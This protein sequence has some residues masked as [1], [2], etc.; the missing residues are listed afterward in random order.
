[1]RD[2]RF[3]RPLV[4]G[5]DAV[6]D[7]VGDHRNPVIFDDHNPHAVGKGKGFGI[8]DSGLGTG[9]DAGGE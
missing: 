8:E 6:P 7:H 3:A 5:A 9:R 4:G 2:P 1:M